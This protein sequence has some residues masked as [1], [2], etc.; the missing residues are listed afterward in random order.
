MDTVNDGISTAPAVVARTPDDAPVVTLG[1]NRVA[2]V[3]HGSETGGRYSLTE[4]MLAPP[5]APGPPAHLHTQEDELVYVLEGALDVEAGGVARTLPAGGIMLVPHGTF[6]SLRNPG[7]GP[8]R[9]LVV[10]TPPGFEGYWAESAALLASGS[11]PDPQAM[12][13]LQQRFGMQTG[14]QARQFA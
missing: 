11:P 10:L 5:P 4:F 3:L 12:L 8:T 1:A 9:M 14:G 6:H 7:P 2:F 13:E